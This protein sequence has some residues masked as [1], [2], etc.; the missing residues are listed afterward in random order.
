MVAHWRSL[1]AA[2]VGFGLVVAAVVGIALSSSPSRSHSSAPLA[3]LLVHVQETG[4]ACYP[5][6][7]C[8]IDQVLG[9]V[10]VVLRSVGGQR[11]FASTDRHG[12]ARF[13]V[14]SGRYSFTLA[15]QAANGCSGGVFPWPPASITLRP[16]RL[17][18]A[19]LGCGQM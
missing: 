11:F 1:T 9:D 3:R 14:P 2:A 5:S 8:V 19:G 15:E 10:D 16:H 6:G 4:G 13:V 12:N 7:R 18:R 17:T